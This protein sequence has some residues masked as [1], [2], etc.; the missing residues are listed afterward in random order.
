MVWQEALLCSH[1]LWSGNYV[2]PQCLSHSLFILRMSTYLQLFTH[3]KKI[4]ISS[5]FS[6]FFPKTKSQPNPFALSP[7]L[8][9]SVGP[10]F[11]WVHCKWPF[12]STTYPQMTRTSWSL[13][14]PLHPVIGK[15]GSTC[16]LDPLVEFLKQYWSW[17]PNTNWLNLNLWGGGRARDFQVILL[18]YGPHTSLHM[19]RLE[20][21]EAMCS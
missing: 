3:F 12:S 14:P 9:W 18:N 2:I 13:K 17:D 15:P 16:A 8:L 21:T 1:A 11:K 6:I 10:S 5:P 20:G 4:K 19:L 7:T